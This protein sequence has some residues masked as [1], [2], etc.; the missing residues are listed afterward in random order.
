MRVILFLLS[1]DGCEF[2]PRPGK[3]KKGK[4]TTPATSIIRKV[5]WSRQ[6]CWITSILI[7]SPVFS[8]HLR[9][10]FWFPF[11]VWIPH[12]FQAVANAEPKPFTWTQT[13]TKSSP[14]SALETN[15]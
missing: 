11:E 5:Y 12:C 9:Y 6:G 8:E 3:E 4:E 13:P 14:L 2:E 10:L 7:G 1:V 15:I